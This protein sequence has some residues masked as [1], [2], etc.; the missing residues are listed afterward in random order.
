[1]LDNLLGIEPTIDEGVILEDTTLGTYT[2]VQAHSVFCNVMVG[3]YSYFAGY[4]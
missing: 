1:M 3:D 2:H 4:N